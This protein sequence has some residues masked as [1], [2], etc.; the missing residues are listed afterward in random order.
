MT[1]RTGLKQ[2]S[3]SQDFG[4]IHGR[5]LSLIALSL[6]LLLFRMS[7]NTS[8][9]EATT[10]TKQARVSVQAQQGGFL[11]DQLIIKFKA[12]ATPLVSAAASERLDALSSAAGQALVYDHAISGD[13]Q[14]LKLSEK[15][16]EADV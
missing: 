8:V 5:K 14:V 1:T 7:I 12:P 9:A 3:A 2:T 11:I 15:M 10:L 4:R 6:T 13:A 16:S